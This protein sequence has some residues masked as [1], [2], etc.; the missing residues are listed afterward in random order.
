VIATL[1]TAVERITFTYPTIFSINQSETAWYCR[2]QWSIN[3]RSDP[4]AWDRFDNDTVTAPL[5]PLAAGFLLSLTKDSKTLLKGGAG[6]FYDRVPLMIPVFE[7]LPDRTTTFLG[8]TVNLS[9]PRFFENRITGELKNPRSTNL[10]LELDKQLL[11]GLLL[12]IAY[13]QR[14]T[15]KDFCCL[16]N[17]ARNFRNYGPLK[18]WQRFLQGISGNHPLSIP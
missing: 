1:D 7:E 15:A 14:N 4:Q 16:A 18:W 3:S 17:L 10:N 11:A 12:R 5:M 13:E 2:D 9:I 8:P 6:I